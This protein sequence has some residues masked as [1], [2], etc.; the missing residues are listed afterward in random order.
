MSQAS[1]RDQ[2]GRYRLAAWAAGWLSF[3]VVLFS[4]AQS[5]SPTINFGFSGFMVA[6]ADN[7][8]I[9]NPPGYPIWVIAGWLW[10]KAA[11]WMGMTEPHHPALAMNFLSAFCGAASA[12]MI[13][14]LIPV[15][16]GRIFR[17]KVSPGIAAVSA[18][19]AALLYAWGGIAWSQSVIADVH[20]M[21]TAILLF[22]LI[23]AAHWLETPDAARAR[24]LYCSAFFFGC[25]VAN[26]RF[27]FLFAPAMFLL[28]ALGSWRGARDLALF[29]LLAAGVAATGLYSP[30]PPPFPWLI[31]GVGGLMLLYLAR[32]TTHGRTLLQTLGWFALGLSWMLFPILASTLG[33]TVQWVVATD[34]QGYL[35]LVTQGQYERIS[36]I[37]NLYAVL[38]QPER[39]QMLAQSFGKMLDWQ[40][41]WP[42]WCVAGFGWLMAALRGRDWRWQVFLTL[43]L[44][45]SGP[46]F[47]ILIHRP[48]NDLQTLAFSRVYYLPFSAV[49][50]LLIG[51]GFAALLSLRSL[52]SKP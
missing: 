18:I 23:T 1:D 34:P 51:Y 49:L 28:P 47:L 50:A 4:Y 31:S 17:G 35:H 15:T 6:A 20:T 39:L 38:H 5:L 8:G 43:I 7:L 42:F 30:F 32:Q 27:G 44:L 11:A 25:L 40:Y 52:W 12:G 26:S 36:P 22:M 37:A 33:T 16:A 14:W 13:A 9:A 3:T 21:N 29:A 19:T 10:I 48:R 41:L 24:C 46:V 2:R 45:L